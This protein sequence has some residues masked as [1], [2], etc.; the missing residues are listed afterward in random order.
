MKAS[1]QRLIAPPTQQPGADLSGASVKPDAKAMDSTGGIDRTD[2]KTLLTNSNREVAE[3]R[4]AKKAGD[5]SGL[6][7]EEFLDRLAEESRPKREVKNKLDKNDF[8]KLF[9]AQ[10]QHQDPLNPDDGAE[11]ASKLAQFNSVEQMMNVNKTLTQLVD[12]QSNQ[13]SLQ[14]INYIGKEVAI[15]G[16]RVRIDNGKVSKPSFDLGADAVETTMKVR[17][18]SGVLVYEKPMGTMKTGTHELD[19]NGKNMEGKTMPG[20]V[21]NFSIHAKSVS[22]EEIP[23][24]LTTKATITGVDIQDVDGGLYTNYGQVKFKDLVSI[25]AKN[26]R[27]TAAKA[28]PA[29]APG[30]HGAA[31]GK[32][33]AAKDPTAPAAGPGAHPRS[34]PTAGT[35]AAAGGPVIPGRTTPAAVTGSAMPMAPAATPTP[36][37]AGVQAAVTGMAPVPRGS[38]GLPAPDNGQAVPVKNPPNRVVV[39]PGMA[40][41]PPKNPASPSPATPARI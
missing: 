20:G 3:E 32:P 13:R 19:W 25:G 26:F 17:D 2:F 12:A 39:K 33:V 34:G 30:E 8:L 23:I 7:E 38:K 5:Y 18:G 27:E 21:Y 41:A 15:D 9:V 10:M 16:G 37:G 1:L 29:T 11:M 24:Q 4:A 40:K 22:G 31:A 36:A 14:L 6:S 35:A 28:A